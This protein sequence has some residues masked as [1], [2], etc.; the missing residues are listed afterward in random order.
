MKKLKDIEIAKVLVKQRDFTTMER[1][2]IHIVKFAKVI[3]NK[4]NISYLAYKGTRITC[5]KMLKIT[6]RQYKLSISQ[7]LKNGSLKKVENYQGSTYV[8]YMLHK[9]FNEFSTL[10][11]SV[12]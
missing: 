5:C 12:H 9:D 7:L 3:D 11:Y 6:A 2:L 10:I 8:S 4:N 1:V